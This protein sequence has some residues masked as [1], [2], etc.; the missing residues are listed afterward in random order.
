M[1]KDAHW[2]ET[3]AC[4]NQARPSRR[5]ILKVGAAS[6]VPSIALSIGS[7]AWGDATTAT[8]TDGPVASLPQQSILKTHFKFGAT[9]EPRLM[10]DEAML[11]GFDRLMQSNDVQ[12]EALYEKL[13]L[14]MPINLNALRR[15]YQATKPDFSFATRSMLID[16]VIGFGLLNRRGHATDEMRG[17]I[18]GSTMDLVAALTRGGK[19]TIDLHVGQ[20]SN[21]MPLAIAYDWLYPFLDDAQRKEIVVALCDYSI[22]PTLEALYGYDGRAFW[23]AGLNNWTT[24]CIG[25]AIAAVLALR[26][27]DDPGAFSVRRKP[28]EATT[29]PFADHADDLIRRGLRNVD[30]AS[31]L[32]DSNGGLWGEGPG[33]QH[34]AV[35]PY[36]ATLVSVESALSSRVELPP[37]ISSFMANARS[38][39]GLHVLSGL[40]HVSPTG[41]EFTYSDGTWSLTNQPINFL[42]AHYARLAGS[43]HWRGGAWQAARC[44]GTGNLAM[45]LLYRGLFDWTENISHPTGM[46]K[47]DIETERKSVYFFGHKAT[48][49]GKDDP[50]ANP[51]VA[52]WR[53]SWTDRDSAAVLIKGGDNRRD[54][55]SHLDVGTFLYDSQ[56]VRWATEVGRAEGY[57]GYRC[58]GL[59]TW[60]P[61]THTTFQVYPKR[62]CGK[63]TLVMNSAVNDYTLRRVPEPW[64]WLWQINPDQ[65]MNEA[66]CWSPL[67]QVQT[68]P[69]ADRW[70]AVVDLLPAYRRHGATSGAHRRFD[71]DRASGALTVTDNLR[72]V[73]DANE[74]WWFM[75]VAVTT[76]PVVTT[77]DRIVFRAVRADGVPVYAELTLLDRPAGCNGFSFGALDERLPPGQPA[78]KWLWGYANVEKQRQQFR[79]VSLQ[80]AGV[81]PTATLSM[82]LRPLKELAGREAVG[83]EHLS[84]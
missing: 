37:E 48:I 61:N 66:D 74:L 22:R 73:S 10:A 69:A 47:F 64:D 63:N 53:Q 62:A 77:P 5:D 75:H 9:S 55:H 29:L 17:Q 30:R 78:D 79:K 26:A 52:I 50:A 57:P 58:D 42:I 41:Q 16:S 11:L 23:V 6:L 82:R 12:I 83:P 51:H 36:F 19:K 2:Q 54:H 59:T 21:M 7:K 3:N 81:G 8:A 28:D 25:G 18:V 35:M 33:Y 24:I 43:S 15:G 20:A 80:A 72:F 13:K 14:S 56:G 70:T 68:D 65:A 45:H 38:A 34:D 27:E 32:I 46:A 71:F 39:A 1:S 67:S 84:Q 4:D 31:M 40:H 60:Q 76:V 49:P 44:G